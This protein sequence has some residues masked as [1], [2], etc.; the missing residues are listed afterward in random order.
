MSTLVPLT[1]HEGITSQM[2]MPSRVFGTRGTF[3]FL[4][5]LDNHQG[6]FSLKSLLSRPRISA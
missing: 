6:S 4:D 2:L 5:L 1:I 3:H